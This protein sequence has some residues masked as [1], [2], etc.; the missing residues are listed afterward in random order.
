[1]RVAAASIN[2]VDYK[3]LLGN[4]A[5]GTSVGKVCVRARAP[6]LRARAPLHTCTRVCT[7][8]MQPA[9]TPPTQSCTPDRAQTL[10]RSPWAQVAG[11]PPYVPGFDLAGVVE[12][13][14]ADCK[15][16]RVG[17]RVWAMNAFTIMGA[18]AE[19]VVLPEACVDTKPANL[20][21][22][23]AASMPLAALTS[24]QAM[25]TAALSEQRGRDGRALA[26]ALRILRANFA[27]AEA[28]DRVLVLGGSG[29]TGVFGVQL[30]A[31]KTAGKGSVAATCRLVLCAQ[32]TMRRLR[33]RITRVHSAANA[34]LVRAQGA[35]TVYDYT[36]PDV[37]D[38]IP[39]ASFDFVYDTVG[40]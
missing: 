5:L 20:T 22:A 23:E 40:G 2:P 3:I 38:A 28:T 7:A 37:I 13:V 6:R 39:S 24:L 31:R 27:R 16:L 14:G 19:L 33:S 15:R 18:F 29:G 4:M 8:A 9:C 17:D 1:V 25:R 12:A 21:F 36:K 10:S 26:L 32:C 30:A 35:A 11:P 34:E